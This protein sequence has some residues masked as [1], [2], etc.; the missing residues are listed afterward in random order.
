MLRPSLLISALAL[1]SAAQAETVANPPAMRVLPDYASL[2]YVG[3]ATGMGGKVVSFYVDPRTVERKDRE[4]SIETTQYSA[5]A[6]PALGREVRFVQMRFTFD[7][8]QATY[9]FGDMVALDSSGK[10]IDK[11]DEVSPPTPI[12]GENTVQFAIR[13][14]V[15]R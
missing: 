3:Q 6:I 12:S 8:A 4:A 7:C 1:A 14:L 11:T 10:V 9:T 13:K 5:T 15:C 2:V